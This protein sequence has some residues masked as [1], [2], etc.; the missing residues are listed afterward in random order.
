MA[1]RLRGSASTVT[2][3][4]AH[5]AG[6]CSAML[7][8]GSSADT[9]VRSRG[10]SRRNSPGEVRTVAVS[11]THAGLPA[12]RRGAST[13]GRSRGRSAEADTAITTMETG[14]TMAAVAVDG[15]NKM[16]HSHHGLN[17]R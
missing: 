9:S 1:G 5:S 6:Q 2:N 15:I 17:S 14:R 3:T 16:M 8:Q 7:R 10:D 13:A 12:T 11:N 4:T